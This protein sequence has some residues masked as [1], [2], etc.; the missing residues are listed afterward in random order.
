MNFVDLSHAVGDVLPQ[1]D[2]ACAVTH[3]KHNKLLCKISL[4]RCVQEGKERMKRESRF[5]KFSHIHG[6]DVLWV[7]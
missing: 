7:H 5:G 1:E 4:H 2:D 3:K 6:E